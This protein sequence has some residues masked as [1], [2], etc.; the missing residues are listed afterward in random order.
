[1]SIL[2]KAF[3]SIFTFPNLVS[4]RLATKLDHFDRKIVWVEHWKALAYQPVF[5]EAG[6]VSNFEVLKQ[7]MANAT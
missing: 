4:K 7:G 6:V 1:M 5:I 3:S 2:G